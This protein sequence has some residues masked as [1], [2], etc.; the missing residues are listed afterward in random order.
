MQTETILKG[1]DEV[2]KQFRLTLSDTTA[3][4][5]KKALGLLGIGVVERM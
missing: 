4:V 2:I 5:L 1:E 3:T